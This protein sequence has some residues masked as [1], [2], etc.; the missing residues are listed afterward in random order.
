MPRNRT[1]VKLLG[2]RISEALAKVGI[3]DERVTAFLGRPCGCA[4]RRQHLNALDLWARRVL[5][6]KSEDAKKYLDEVLENS[7]KGK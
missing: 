1:D 2:D 6:G 4:E 3:T 5:S 7:D